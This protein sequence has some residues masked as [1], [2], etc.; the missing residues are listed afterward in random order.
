MEPFTADL[1]S[2]EDA[3]ALLLGDLSP[4]ISS[5]TLNINEALGWVTAEPIISPLNVPS[6]DNSA[7]DGYA[8]RLS[9]LHGVETLPIA[10]QAFA[11]NPYPGSLPAGHV[12]QIMTGAPIPEGCEAV[13]MQ[14]QTDRTTQ[15]IQLKSAVTA[16]Q[17]IRR[18][19]EDIRQGQVVLEAGVRLKVKD[20]PLLAS[21]GIQNVKVIRPL[22]V[23]IFSTGDELV[24][25]GNPLAAGQ[26]YDTNR[27]AISL[28]LQRL[29][30]NVIDLG[31]IPDNKPSL[32]DA[33]HR[34]DH[35]ADLVIS[36]GGVSVGA[37]DYTR[38]VLLA[39]GDIRFWKL[40]MK[41]GKPFAFG[42]LRESLFCGLP[43]N[44]VSAVV[45]FCQLVYPMILR[46]QGIT[47]APFTSFTA[48][49]TAPIT[50]QP[51]RTEFQRGYYRSQHGEL[52][53]TADDKQ[54]SHMFSTFTHANCFICL[55]RESGSLS[56][57]E[58]VTI[59]PFPEFL[60]GA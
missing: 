27:F 45:T 59:Q 20:L 19:G 58:K 14:E 6:F 15:G 56:Q 7:M 44:P 47:A 21:L 22:R 1:L 54:G 2:V 57:G 46:L 28:M 34:A 49:L 53:V 60:D 52:H 41:P 55:P 31:I 30:C 37:A 39:C 18:V 43:G 10:G 13:I 5:Q 9:D 29:G 26:I 3:Q 32:T 48:T 42:R 36:T 11:G 12:V 35:Q 17:N 25:P 4:L 8:L 23:A 16:G 38:D 24:L 40:A 33:F 51:G 50:K